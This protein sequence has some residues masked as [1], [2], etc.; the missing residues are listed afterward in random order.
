[1]SK[2]GNILSF[3]HQLQVRIICWQRLLHPTSKE[4]R[5]RIKENATLVVKELLTTLLQQINTSKRQTDS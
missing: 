1:M 3:N 5:I 4:L 2:K